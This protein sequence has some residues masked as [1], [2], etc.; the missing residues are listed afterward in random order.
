[1]FFFSHFLSILSALIS[2]LLN[3]MRNSVNMQS[4]STYVD[5][6]I[7][8][9]NAHF[10]WPLKC[11]ALV[12]S[13]CGF[14]AFAVVHHMHR[15]RLYAFQGSSPQTKATSLEIVQT[16]LNIFSAARL[17]YYFCGRP[18]TSSTTSKR[19]WCVAEQKW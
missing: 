14:F 12:V 17:R 6:L 3:G 2:R 1:M 19:F 16:M 15:M 7:Q 9:K 18:F 11:T 4:K 13:P 5:V 10:S 8:A